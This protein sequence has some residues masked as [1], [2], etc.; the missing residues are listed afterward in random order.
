MSYDATLG[1]PNQTALISHEA[2]TAAIADR[3]DAS[4]LAGKTDDQK[5]VIITTAT[6][7]WDAVWWQ[8][9]RL[10][11]SYQR[12]EW[13]R[14]A[15]VFGT[16]AVDLAST[17]VAAHRDVF[18]RHTF[19]ATV[20]SGTT[21][22]ATITAL[23]AKPEIY[24]DD[25]FN[26]GSIRIESGTGADLYVT[27]RITDFVSSTGAITHEAFAGAT[28][29]K[30]VQIVPPLHPLVVQAF[31]E[32]CI[33]ITREGSGYADIDRDKDPEDLTTRIVDAMMKKY[34]RRTF[35]AV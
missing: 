34:R 16:L 19:G 29:G 33:T 21:T 1:S 13:P 24:P 30:S 20:N 11:P 23:A 17:E 6:V 35:D 18:H 27:K 5:K 9:V 7:Y 4:L 31:V 12:L 8:G 15:G 2:L 28:T 10:W 14:R 25:W 26:E 22:E 3:N 32:L